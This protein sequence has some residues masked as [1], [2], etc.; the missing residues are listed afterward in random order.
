MKIGKLCNSYV[1]VN[2]YYY[3]YYLESDE[4]IIKSHLVIVHGRIVLQNT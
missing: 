2:Y 3:Y 1:V 4:R